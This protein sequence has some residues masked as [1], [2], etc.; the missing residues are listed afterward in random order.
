MDVVVIGQAA[1][2]QCCRPDTTG[3][4]GKAYIVSVQEVDAVDDV[5]SYP[6]SVLVPFQRW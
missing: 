2:A 5:Q 3:F 6:C 4:R 1:L